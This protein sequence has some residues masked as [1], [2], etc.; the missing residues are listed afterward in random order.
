MTSAALAVDDA[1]IKNCEGCHGENG[2]SKWSDIPTIAGISG[3]VH[4]DALYLYRDE[5]RPCEE[6]KYPTDDSKPATSMCAVAKDLSDEQIQEIAAHYAAL[7][8]VPADQETDAAKVAQGMKVHEE[9]C[10]KCHSD[11]GSNA[12]D[13]ASILAGQQMG[14]LRQ[15]FK[16]FAA[17]RPQPS[18]MEKNLSELSDADIEALVQYYGSQK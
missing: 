12:G 11:G 3:I 16:D 10:A 8:F 18:K 14:Y 5:E 9:H 6:V 17:G 1:L 7:P 2:V 4:E 15:A 13:D